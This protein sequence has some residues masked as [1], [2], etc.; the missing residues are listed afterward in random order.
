MQATGTHYQVGQ[1]RRHDLQ[2]DFFRGRYMLVEFLGLDDKGRER[3]TVE[4]LADDEQ[5]ET[6]ILDFYAGRNDEAGLDRE[7]ADRAEYVGTTSIFAL[8][9]TKSHSDQWSAAF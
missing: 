4:H 8:G 3:W 7:I 5:S 6:A 1:I 2:S 9:F